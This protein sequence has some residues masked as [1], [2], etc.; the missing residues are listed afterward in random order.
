MIG[1]RPLLLLASLVLLAG[2]S[3]AEAAPP[4]AEPAAPGVAAPRGAPE[5][6]APGTSETATPGAAEGAAPEAAPGTPEAP[7]VP[8]AIVAEPRAPRPQWVT[9]YADLGLGGPTGI[10]GASVVVRAAP[11]WG[12]DLGGGLGAT[13]Y[14]GSARA[15]VKLLVDGSGQRALTLSVGPT[16][17]LQARALK[18]RIPHADDEREPSVAYTAWMN[19]ALG[20]SFVDQ[21]TGI[22]VRLELGASVRMVSTQADLCRGVDGSAVD[23]GGDA[24]CKSM[25]LATAPEIARHVVLPSLMLSGGWSL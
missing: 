17:G 1:S 22:S 11:R 24:A 2:A 23:E 4:A 18:M 16:M 3:R 19:A 15:Q 14:Q 9:L 13:G 10:F 25:H 20:V 7:V 6:T 12:V 8:V 21:P 5:A